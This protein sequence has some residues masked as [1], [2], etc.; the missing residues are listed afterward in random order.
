MKK[1]ALILA[2]G[3]AATAPV[4][5]D[6]TNVLADDRS[7]ESY[8]LGMY[9]GRNLQQQGVEM[10]WNLYARGFKDA[11]SGGALLLTEQ[12]MRD[13]L[14]ALQKTTSAK[15]QQIREG[16]AAKY[17]AESDAFLAKN[18]TQ[19]GVVTLSDGLQ[20]KIITE[21]NGEVPGDNNTILMN[22]RGTLVDG[23]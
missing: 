9:Y 16:Q 3:L 2:F 17:K 23:T 21:G 6:G 15:Q 5:A 18:K 7:R 14:T 22:F 19:P 13:A 1:T 20:Y 10:D 12:Q 8:A 11:Q 4:L